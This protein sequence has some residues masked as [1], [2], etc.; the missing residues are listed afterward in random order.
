MLLEPG[1]GIEEVADQLLL[2]GAQLLLDPQHVGDEAQALL[3]DLVAGKV[4]LSLYL[5]VNA[6]YVVQFLMKYKVHKRCKYV[7]EA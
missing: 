1:H 6:Q 7:Y 5:Q 3:A 4:G 2:A